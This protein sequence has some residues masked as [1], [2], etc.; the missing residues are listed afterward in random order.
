MKFAKKQG[1]FLLMVCVSLVL[2]K[3]TISNEEVLEDS[4]NLQTQ[5]EIQPLSLK[6]L[7]HLLSNRKIHREVHS[8]SQECSVSKNNFWSIG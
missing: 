2:V 6:T 3:C 7:M 5:L 1:L 8:L 4:P